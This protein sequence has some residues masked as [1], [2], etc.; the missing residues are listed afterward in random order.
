MSSF[1]I[2]PKHPREITQHGQTR[3][4]DYYWMRDRQ[5]P[6]TLKHL[7]AA[8]FFLYSLTSISLLILLPPVG[9]VGPLIGSVVIMKSPV[10][11]P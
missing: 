4:D 1:P 6:E 10:L 9:W 5:N 2:A 7:H 11:H 8:C 3:V